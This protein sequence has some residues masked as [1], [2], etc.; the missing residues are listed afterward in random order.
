M[1]K[2]LFSF[3]LFNCRFSLRWFK[4]SEREKYL[5]LKTK[6]CSETNKDIKKQYLQEITRIG[7]YWNF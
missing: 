6:M 3:T 1:G 2:I 4:K 7:D 5:R